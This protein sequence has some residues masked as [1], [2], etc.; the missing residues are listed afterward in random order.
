MPIIRLTQSKQ[1][2]VDSIDADF[3]SQWKWYFSPLPDG[4]G[5]AARN[6]SL[7]I[8][9]QRKT[10]LMHRVIAERSGLDM[11][12]EIDHRDGDKL[13]NRRDNLRIATS[14]QNKMNRPPSKGSSRFKGVSWRASRNKW[15]ATIN[16]DGKS[17]HIGYFTTELEA[18]IAYNKFAIQHQGP[19][20]RLNPVHQCP[21]TISRGGIPQ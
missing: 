14:S 15:R 10:I 17:K 20:A 18:A 21:Q 11:G 12:L 4:T 5:Y 1:A 16:I 2:L 8:N 19:F 3:L 9:P 13:N 6:R 7:K